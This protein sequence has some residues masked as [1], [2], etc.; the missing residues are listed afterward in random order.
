MTEPVG[1][2]GC[3]AEVPEE[4]EA[5]DEHEPGGGGADGDHLAVVWSYGALGEGISEV[6]WLQSEYCTHDV[7]WN[8]RIMQ[9]FTALAVERDVRVAKDVVN[10]TVHRWLA[11]LASFARLAA[12]RTRS[13]DLLGQ[14]VSD[15]YAPSSAQLVLQA[16]AYDRGVPTLPSSPHIIL[17]GIQLHLILS[18]RASVM[19]ALYSCLSSVAHSSRA[20]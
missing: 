18:H 12:E 15:I 16:L 3:A 1:M 7:A 17:P 2:F 20:Q 5:E 9:A 11:E 4:G 14:E 8:L 10:E 13:L 6:K 19:L